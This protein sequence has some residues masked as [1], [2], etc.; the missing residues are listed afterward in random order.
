MNQKEFKDNRNCDILNEGSNALDISFIF[1]YSF[2]LNRS[3]TLRKTL[4]FFK[5]RKLIDVYPY[6]VYDSGI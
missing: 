6:V 1:I 2:T 4:Y 3:K 5:F